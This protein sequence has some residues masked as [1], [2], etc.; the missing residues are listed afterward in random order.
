MKLIKRF[1]LFV[2]LLCS[3]V[4]LVTP[5]HAVPPATPDKAF[6]GTKIVSNESE[7]K[8]I[9]LNYF[10]SENQIEEG[11]DFGFE[12]FS[13]YSKFTYDENSKRLIGNSQRQASCKEGLYLLFCCLKIHFC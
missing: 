12:I 9:A 2:L 6:D 5:G 8:S 10:D 4:L 7:I 13:S 1:C 11:N 3:G